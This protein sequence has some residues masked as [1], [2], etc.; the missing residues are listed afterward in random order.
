MTPTAR[1]G[2]RRK[3]ALVGV[4]V[5]LLALLVGT[6]AQ[7]SLLTDGGTVNVEIPNNTTSVMD[8]PTN[9][10]ALVSY[11]G[12]S[13]PVNGGLGSSGTGI[14][15]PFVRIQGSPTEKGYNTD[16]KVEFDTKTGTWT[17][18]MLVSSIPVRPCP[19]AAIPGQ[20]CFEL[21]NDI[22]ENNTAK[23]ISLNKV[24]VYFA[25]GPGAA[26]LV[27]YPFSSPP[28]GTTVTKQYAFDGQVQI[29]DVNQGSGRGDLR[30]DIPVSF[31]DAAPGCAYNP[32]STTCQTYFVLYSEWGVTPTAKYSS[33]GGFEEWKVKTYPVPPTLKLVKSVTNDNG[34]SA[35]PGD[36]TLTATGSSAGFSDLGSSTTFHVVTAGVQYTLSET[37]VAGYTAGT[38]W[39][40]DGGTFATPDKITLAAAA[41]VTCTITN[42]DNPPSLT[43]DKVVVNDNGG[44]ALES[45]WTLTA[46]GGTAGTLSGAGAAGSTDVVSGATFKAGTYA[47]SESA[48]PATGYTN[49]TTYSCVKTPAGGSAGSA[50][51]SNSITLANGDSAVCTIT[52][53]DNP[54]SPVIKTA[55]GWSLF[56]TANLTGI[57]ANAP[58][59]GSATVTFKLWS[60]NTAGVCSGL[61]GT[62]TESITSGSATTSTGIVVSP[63][64]SPTTYYWTA[65]YS[66]DQFNSPTSSPCGTE[67]TTISFVQAP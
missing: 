3:W 15:V 32:A 16:G 18:S 30:Y 23:N 24:E 2:A 59:A 56:D 36:W 35:V 50:V 6:V 39:S 48:G 47:L 12:D 44:T 61:L 54:A 25:T 53:D 67:T 66:G 27:G 21:W 64:T 60:T 13:D 49:G 65:D 40:C 51:L 46:N 19:T 11:I 55:Q 57:L 28:A 14:F 33:D 31:F 34:G 63:T 43:L 37:A 10:K 29:N 22:N 1:R 7:A 41:Q 8:Q 5:A 52:N 4:T 45:A 9:A 62:R 58:N 42:N 17:H 20:L 26:T 38:T